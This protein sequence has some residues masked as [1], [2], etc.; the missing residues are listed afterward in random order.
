[1][2]QYRQGTVSVTNNSVTVLGV[3]TEWL[4]NIQPGNLFALKNDSVWYS[5]AAV[6]ADGELTLQTPYAGETKTGAAYNIHR[7]FTANFSLPF[8]TYG[9]EN[10]GS[11]LGAALSSLD[12][13]INAFGSA[14]VFSGTIS[15]LFNIQKGLTGTPTKSAGLVVKRG[16]FPDASILFRDDQTNKRWELNGFGLGQI[17]NMHVAGSV[18]IGVEPG[19]NKFAVN[20]NASIQGNLSVSGTISGIINLGDSGVAAGTYTKLTVDNRGIVTSAGSILTSDITTALGFTPFSAAGGTLS[21]SLTVT[22]DLV[23]QGDT[24]TLNTSA[25][26]VEDAVITVGSANT[27]ITPYLGLKAERGDTDA[28]L[29]FNESNDRWQALMSANDLST[30]GTLGVIEAATFYGA[31]SGNATT[32]TALATARTI[33]G[34]SFNG[35]ANISFDTDSVAEGATNLYFT[36]TRGRAA[37]SAGTGIAYNSTTGVVSF[38]GAT[39]SIDISNVNGLQTALDAKATLSHTHGVAQIIDIASTYQ[40]L[41]GK[42]AANGYAGLNTNSRVTSD[43]EG[44]VYTTA[45]ISSV[46]DLDNLTAAGEYNLDVAGK[47]NV[48]SAFPSGWIFVW[49]RT[50]TYS[51]GGTYVRQYAT[52]MDTISSD[53]Y[54]RQK[55]TGSWSSW[56]RI[57]GAIGTAANNVVALNASA[58]IDSTLL[59]LVKADVGL[60]NVDNTSDA[61]KPI[62]TAQQAALNGKASLGKLE[63]LVSDATTARTLALTDLGQAVE[64]TNAAANTVTVPPNSSV[65]F[66][67]N[68][69]IP[70]IQMGT[71]QTTIAAGAGVTIRSYG[72]KLK[73]VGQYAQATLYKRATDEWV[74]AGGLVA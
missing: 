54:A 12:A 6:G 60:G 14:S 58:K 49:V 44:L 74:L 17:G 59:T 36:Q 1:M 41:S 28:Y 55:T 34:V 16:S 53:I 50:H 18:G 65:A 32:A 52:D 70:I 48:P 39:V 22:G 33:N 66:P 40:A 42:N 3:G 62:S 5:I 2:S 25:L 69:V 51:S 67:L 63:G 9:D 23:V 43:L 4:V 72:N 71:G 15:N 46:T 29:V 47:A 30:A 68:A 27:G 13:A 10:T 38:N 20:G 64:M 7:D 26:S 61:N 37:I 21:G 19:T 31:L 8:P 35:S 73:L 11:L 45:R 24:I 57:A 56:T